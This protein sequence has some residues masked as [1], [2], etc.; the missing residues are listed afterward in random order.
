M[1]N[2]SN[3]GVTWYTL[4]YDVFIVP[5]PRS[6]RHLFCQINFTDLKFKSM[7]ELSK[8]GVLQK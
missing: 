3:Y 5:Q 4:V 7:Y 1:H 2:I 8:R 6:F